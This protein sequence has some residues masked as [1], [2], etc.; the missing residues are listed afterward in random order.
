MVGSFSY[1]CGGLFGGA[2]GFLVSLDLLAGGVLWCSQCR[3]LYILQASHGS[4][5]ICSVLFSL[6]KSVERVLDI[7][8]N[9]YIL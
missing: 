4:M 5:F 9:I 3:M 1:D 7:I 8:V 2:D 6:L